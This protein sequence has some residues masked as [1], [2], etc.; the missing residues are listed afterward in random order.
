M[1]KTVRIE[2]A[3]NNPTKKVQ[4]EI[5]ENGQFVKFEELPY[6]TSL[7]D[8]TLWDGRELRIKEVDVDNGNK[9]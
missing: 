9:D 7:R 3:D 6:P 1:T 2:N 5:W 8:Y 4:V